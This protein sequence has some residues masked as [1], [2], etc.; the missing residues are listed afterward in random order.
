MFDLENMADIWAFTYN[1]M[2]NVFVD[3]TTM[4][5]VPEKDRHQNCESATVLSKK[6][7]NL[8]FDLVKMAAIMDFTH[9]AMSR[10]L[11]LHTTMLGVPENHLINTKIINHINLLFDLDQMAYMW[12][13]D[14][15]FIFCLA[16][17]FFKKNPLYGHLYEIWCLYHNL[18]DSPSPTRRHQQVSSKSSSYHARLKF[19][20]TNVIYV[21]TKV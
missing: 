11:S 13:N 15:R 16:N 18:N 7:I 9:N 19:S 2:F 5:G 17:V 20:K 12:E 4:P 3:H 14:D 21:L 6:N 10:E 1:A 8:L